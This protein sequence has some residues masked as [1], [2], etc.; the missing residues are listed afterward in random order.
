MFSADSI[1]VGGRIYVQPHPQGAE[2]I[3]EL[4]ACVSVFGIGS[5]VEKILDKNT[6]DSFGVTARFVARWAEQH[7]LLAS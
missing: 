7:G 2:H 5:M 1:Y 3:C 4:E 6:R